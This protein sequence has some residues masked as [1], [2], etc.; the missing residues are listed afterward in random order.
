M[1]VCGWNLTAAS[2][3][4]ADGGGSINVVV[5]VLDLALVLVW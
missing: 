3:G 2:G 5:L 4:S 1:I